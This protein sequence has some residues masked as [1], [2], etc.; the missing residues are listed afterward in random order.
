MAGR[1]TPGPQGLFEDKKNID[2]GTLART[3]TLPPGVDLNYTW[4]PKKK[5]GITTS[6]AINRSDAYSK[7]PGRIVGKVYFPVDVDKLDVD[8][9]LALAPLMNSLEKRLLEEFEITLFCVGRTDYRASDKYNKDL[10]RR[11]QDNVAKFIKRY[12]LGSDTATNEL[13]TIKTLEPLG[14]SIAEQPGAAGK[15]PSQWVMG[16]DRSVIIWFEK[17]SY[18]PPIML[19]F[20]GDISKSKF[21]EAME[22]N[23]GGKIKPGVVARK[24]EQ[25]H[26]QSDRDDQ[27]QN[28]E[29]KQNLKDDPFRSIVDIRFKHFI[30]RV[31]GKEH[32]ELYCEAILV[33]TGKILFS[34]AVQSINDSLHEF[35]Y[36]KIYNELKNKH[37]NITTRVAKMLVRKIAKK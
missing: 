29:G 25:G 14:E 2:S 37:Q 20:E 28:A 33:D 30:K 8:D 7:S 21:I 35:D 12:V 9:M 5:E 15:K 32:G 1:R 18:L 11:R 17:E 19:A 26:L 24:D 36:K 3:R 22:V 10:S 13:F 4:N 31:A 34:L 16:R 23:A 27:R 6:S